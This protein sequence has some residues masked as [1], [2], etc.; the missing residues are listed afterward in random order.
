MNKPKTPQPETPDEVQVRD[1]FQTP[2]YATKLLLPFLNSISMSDIDVVW[3]C[4]VGS[5]KIQR[6]IL[7]S[8]LDCFGSDLKEGTNFLTD[9]PPADFDC[10]VTNPPFS[11]KEEFYKKC[12]G[13]GKPFALLIPADNSIW[14]WD[15]VH[16]H[17]CERILPKRRIDYLTPNILDIVC[18]G[19]SFMQLP[20]TVR[21]A[22]YKNKPTLFPRELWN[23]EFMFPSIEECPS[24]LLAKWSTSQFHSMWLTKGFNLGS[25]E[26]GVDL[27]VEMKLDI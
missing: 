26:I 13:Y 17:G 6:V 25:P 4:A 5:G 14:L 22:D 24:E 16:I 3:E 21:K 1:D 11:L 15:A 18:R 27:T 23:M 8:G 19:E 7:E 2:A 12:M 20:A 9:E 10:I